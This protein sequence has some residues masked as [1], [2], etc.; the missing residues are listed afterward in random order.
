MP[1]LAGSSQLAAQLRLAS[2]D[3]KRTHRNILEHRDQAI[4]Q[5]VCGFGQIGRGGAGERG[6][7]GKR[8]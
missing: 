2:K 5:R 1:D 3:A 7:R 6:E 8:F 4:R